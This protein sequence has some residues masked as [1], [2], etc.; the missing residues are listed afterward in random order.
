M[1]MLLAATAATAGLPV[2]AARAQGTDQRFAEPPPQKPTSS[3]SSSSPSS[4]PAPQLTK[5]PTLI[6]PPQPVYPPQA[7]AQKLAADVTLQID[8][9]ADGHVA[10]VSVVTPVGNGFDQAA[11]AA[12]AEMEFSPAEVDGKPAKIRIQYVLHF[13]PEVPPPPEPPPPPAPPPAPTVPAAAAPPEPEL[14]RGR[15]REKGTREPIGA[16][17]VA[18]IWNV[19]APPASSSPPAPPPTA[20]VVTATDADGRFVLRGGAPGGLRLI[21]SDA[22]HEACI[23][24]VRPEQLAGGRVVELSCFQPLRSGGQYETRVRGQREHEEVTRHTLSHDELTSVPGTFGDPL[25]VIQNLPG[26]AR[27]PYG[28]GQLIVRGAAPQ[29]TG[30]F[31]DGQK[32][33]YVFHFLGGPSVLTPTLIDKIDF[34][35]GGFGVRYGRVTAGILDVSLR[36]EPLTQV[37]GSADVNLLDS[38][39]SV[40]GPLGHG[41]SGSIA[42]RRSYIDLLLPYVIPQRVGSS[43]VVATPVY[44]DYQTRAD[45]DLGAAGRLSL[46]VFGSNDSLHVLAQDPARGDIDL[47]SRIGFHRVVA[48]WTVA[49]GGWLS[50]LSPAYGYDL[51]RFG[52]GEVGVDRDTHLLTLREELTRSLTRSL[53]LALGVDVQAA[54]DK[55]HLHIPTPAITRTFGRSAPELIDID[56]PINDLGSAAYA[57]AIWDVSRSVRLVPGVRFD[58]FHYNRTDRAS[59]D[60]RLVARWAL[61]PRLAFKAGVGIFHQPQE[62]QILDDQFGNPSLPLIWSDQYHLGVERRFTDVI[63]LDAT[64]Y[65]LGRHNLPVRDA[66]ERFT[67]D[68]RGRSYG[69]EVLLRHEITRNFYGWIS[70]TLSRAEQTVPTVGNQSFGMGGVSAPAS[71]TQQT[72]YP[73]PFDQTHNLIA[74][75]SYKLRAWELGAR[76]RLVSGVPTTPTEGAVYDSDYGAYRPVLG[77]AYSTRRQLFHQLDVRVERTFTRDWW[78]LGIYLDIQNVYNAQNPE[79]TT[80][81]Y[82]YR[83]S[84]PVRG[85]P[86]LPILGVRGRF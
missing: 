64:V 28:L 23:R 77:P 25:R 55:T 9:D 24:D 46:A 53:K 38:S 12:A 49:A 65:Y 14:V 17:D 76:F 83:Q 72:Y 47:G 22:E 16:A 42:A 44:W 5:P 6:K 13:R 82:R 15:V 68:G 41:V 18:V 8:I 32:V 37:H 63:S 40:E 20:H 43:T 4:A 52:A 74:I 27:V 56:R 62:P 29:D 1:L 84:A 86:F 69:L 79:A 81:D 85:L 35:P 71:T 34:Y 39:A 51:Y 48:T 45:K 59:V 11:T 3:S 19:F 21:I 67:A 61:S 57:E 75:A 2:P 54:F 70:Y 58:Q 80:F 36:N 78:R 60:P 50:R 10:G 73:T 7:L 31:I 26:V 33:P 66:Q 30:V